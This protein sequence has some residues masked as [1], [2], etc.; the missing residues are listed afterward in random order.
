MT[1]IDL[2]SQKLMTYRHVLKDMESSPLKL[3]NK[4]QEYTLKTLF[5]HSFYTVLQNGGNE[6]LK[7]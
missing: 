6:A 7:L 4:T 3:L 1:W 2:H 5:L